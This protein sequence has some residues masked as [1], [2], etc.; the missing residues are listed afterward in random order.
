MRTRQQNRIARAIAGVGFPA[1][2]GV[3]AVTSGVGVDGRSTLI[4]RERLHDLRSGASAVGVSLVALIQRTVAAGCAVLARPCEDRGGESRDDDR[5]GESVFQR[6]FLFRSP[7]EAGRSAQ[8][9][10]IDR[11]APTNADVQ[12]PM[13]MIGPKHVQRALTPES[14]LHA[15]KPKNPAPRIEATSRPKFRVRGTMV[16]M[17]L[18]ASAPI[19]PQ[20][21][22]NPTS[23]VASPEAASN[24][25]EGAGSI[26][27]P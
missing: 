21:I 8:R 5:E 13:L 24:R 4:V 23:V 22:I 12:G 1:V 3:S 9:E 25:A 27:L 7:Q 18:S 19:T 11:H 16:R 6:L 2:V 15:P 10:A 20:T 26:D 14:A 17:A